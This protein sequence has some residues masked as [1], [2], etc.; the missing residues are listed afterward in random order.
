[1]LKEYQKELTGRNAAIRKLYK[2][3]K[4]TLQQLAD[5]YGVSRARIDQIVR[6]GKVLDKQ[7]K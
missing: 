1:M 4:W 3:G 7:E 5:K 6:R 2:T